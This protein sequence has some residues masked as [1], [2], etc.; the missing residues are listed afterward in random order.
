[1]S[2]TL[3]YYG[4]YNL[5]IQTHD[6][7]SFLERKKVALIN[8]N[9]FKYDKSDLDK[10]TEEEI[11]IMLK[12]AI[13]K[14]TKSSV[15][16]GMTYLIGPWGILYRGLDEKEK[17]EIY[18]LDFS[19][20][21]FETFAKNYLIKYEE[22]CI[23]LLPEE[24]KI[25]FN[26]KCFTFYCQMYGNPKITKKNFIYNIRDYFILEKNG[27]KFVGYRNE[28]EFKK[29]KQEMEID[30]PKLKE[31]C[32]INRYLDKFLSYFFDDNDYN[33]EE[34]KNI[35]NNYYDDENNN[36]TQIKTKED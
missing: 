15:N 12:E 31:K 29:I 23:K 4:Q 33:I 14:E 11:N 24:M 36:Y 30:Y 32:G 35:L 8:T 28:K 16:I 3:Y 21:S 20:E 26:D 9:P 2:S 10:K 34:T 25:C 5:Y 6:K 17:N 27:K 19:F 18:K 22:N 1:M 13:I 7:R